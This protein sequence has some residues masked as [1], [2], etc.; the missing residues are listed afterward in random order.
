MFGGD[1]AW[2]EKRDLRRTGKRGRVRVAYRVCW[3]G[4]DGKKRSKTFDRLAPA[5]QFAREVE[6][7][8]Q[9]GSYRDPALARV[10]LGSYG[11]MRLSR[12]SVRPS[13]RD[14]YARWLRLYVEPTIGRVRLGSLTPVLLDDWIAAMRQEGV[15]ESTV[16]HAHGLVR[17]V[18]SDAVREG[19]LPEN[20]AARMGVVKP[21]PRPH[22][23]LTA[24]ELAAIARC[25]EPRF[26]ALVLLLGLR[27]LRIGEA[28]ALTPA[29]LDLSRGSVA[30]TKSSV[31][32]AGELIEGPTKTAAGRRA[33]ALPPFLTR[34]LEWH[35]ERFSSRWVFTTDAG[36]QVRAGNFRRREFARA[37]R[38]AAI[39]AP[40]P[41]LH[42]LRHTA[43]SLAAA[44]GAH[45]T[46]VREMLGHSD[47]A[48]TLGIYTHVFPAAHAETAWR[49]ERL[50]REAGGG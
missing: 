42:D 9:S 36:A 14:G 31:E 26:R 32:V 44:A 17:R 25:I 19:R 46:E 37:V 11:A 3:R 34:E 5:E 6:V 30:V 22:R 7:A 10:T 12:W 2:I 48:V 27:G 18:L 35:V 41:T 45:P 28:V 20:P 49:L 8:K 16:A 15:G 38:A 24:D 4:S 40:A 33:V 13:T 47:V 43:A 21:Q 29:D 1:M 50:W 23:Y 39:P